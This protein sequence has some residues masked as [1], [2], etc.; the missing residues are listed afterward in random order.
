MWTGTKSEKIGL[1]SM[2]ATN[3]VPWVEKKPD[4]KPKAAREVPQEAVFSH[5]DVLH[6][7]FGLLLPNLAR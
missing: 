3:G 7:K 5:R 2:P 1:E 6:A 4:F